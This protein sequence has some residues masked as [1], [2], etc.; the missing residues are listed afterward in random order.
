MD[1]VENIQNIHI[2][3]AIEKVLIEK[4][5]TKS[6]FGK[7]IN[8]ERSSVYDIL[9]RKSID[10]DLLVEISKVLDYDF[11]RKLY[12]DEET[13]PTVYIAI[14]TSKEEINKMNLSDE[15]IYLIKQNT[16]HK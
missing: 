4:S 14:K 5:M 6:D 16:S 10:T 13:S 1:F 7:K 2:G 12:Y 9:K 11:I 15:F 3:S 8:H